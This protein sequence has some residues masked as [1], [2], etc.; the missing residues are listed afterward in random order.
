MCVRAGVGLCEEVCVGGFVCGGWS[1][2]VV[3][4]VC[5]SW[6]LSVWGIVGGGR[7]PLWGRCSKFVCVLEVR[8]SVRSS[9]RRLIEWRTTARRCAHRLRAAG[10]AE[11]GS[12]GRRRILVPCLLHHIP[13]DWLE[14]GVAT[15]WA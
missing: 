3:G 15:L 13:P 12:R 14:E 10:T 9:R 6:S 5:G 8:R 4:G 11:V 2:S 1:L 7:R